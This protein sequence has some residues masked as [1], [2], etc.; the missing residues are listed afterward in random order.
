MFSIYEAFAAQANS[1]P[2]A[3]AVTDGTDVFT[4]KALDELAA[5]IQAHLPAGMRRAGIVMDHGPLMI[6]SILAVL[7][8]G[9]AYV[10]VEPDFPKRR[11][12]Y[13]FKAA[14]VDVVVTQA[15][16]EDRFAK[17]YPTLV[18][19][20]SFATDATDA[21]KPA[22]SDPDAAAYILFTS[23]STGRPKG[24]V[25]EN[26]NVVHYVNAFREEFGIGPGDV[27]L[28][29]SVCTFDI[30]VEEMFGTLL[31]GGELAI[32]SSCTR[33]N[34]SC[35]IPFI[36]QTGVTIVS[37]F[38]YLML[39]F[40]RLEKLPASIRLLIS[41]GD[42]LRYTQVDKLLRDGHTVYN[43]YGPSETTVCATYHRCSAEDDL[44]NGVFPIGHPVKGARVVVEDEQGNEAKPGELGEICIF[45]A[46]V[47]RGYLPGVDNSAFEAY[48]NERGF[49]S[50]DLGYI[51][52]DGTIV[53]VRRRDTQIMIGGKRVE[54]GEVENVLCATD[55]IAAAHVLAFDD[56]CGQ[57]YLT[58]YIVADE[59]EVP[60]GQIKERL[61]EYLPSFMIPEFF[62][63]MPVVPLTRNGKPDF[64]LFPV[65]MKQGEPGA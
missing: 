8:A 24:I 50:G 48:A 28:Q 42:I 15:A 2:D 65:V 39:D 23:G 32:P 7:R 40:N 22:D 9:G 54:T 53:F 16:Y 34:M 18:P 49:R 27:M 21:P 60:L 43:T 12:G 17:R 14:D 36:E 62:V 52:P 37:G 56:A 31:N 63:R 58:A 38:P 3:P 5:G 20:F 13:M 6:A 19:D 51:L 10:P 55:G 26:A 29:L 4:Y 11:V 33:E 57:P 30:F 45:G 35:L 41:G 47:T 64:D 1:H 59:W 44:D 61:R 25:A 46:G